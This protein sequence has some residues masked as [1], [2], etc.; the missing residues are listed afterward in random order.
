M[1]IKRFL[2]CFLFFCY[3][4]NLSA[5]IK[6][7]VTYEQQTLRNESEAVDLI[8]HV[9]ITSADN[10][11]SIDKTDPL[12]R[13]WIVKGNKFDGTINLF[14]SK[15]RGIG[16]N[17]QFDGDSIRAIIASDYKNV[18][19]PRLISLT[20]DFMAGLYFIENFDAD[21]NS[22]FAI[23]SVQNTWDTDVEYTGKYA[24]E[25]QSSKP[26]GAGSWKVKQGKLK[27]VQKLH[28]ATIFTA[29]MCQNIRHLFRDYNPDELEIN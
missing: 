5:G 23:Y 22:S 8:N 17:F 18:R 21:C 6:L 2:F 4:I 26:C 14:V 9:E 3:A 20:T 28:F 7:K 19:D 25:I 13:N 12:F 1:F 29:I 15:E 10:S 27:M 16:W 24:L 11:I